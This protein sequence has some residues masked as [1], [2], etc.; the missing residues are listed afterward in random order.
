MVL[1]KVDLWVASMDGHLAEKMVLKMD[2]LKV[3]LLAVSSVC[4]LVVQRVGR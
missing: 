4:Y 3:G 2:D 1:P